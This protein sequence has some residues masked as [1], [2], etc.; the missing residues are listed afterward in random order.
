M[1]GGNFRVGAIQIAETAAFAQYGIPRQITVQR[2]TACPDQ[3]PAVA[4]A[5]LGFAADLDAGDTQMPK[6]QKKQRRLPL[7][8]AGG[9]EDG[10]DDGV[11]AD[12]VSVY[13][14]HAPCE[15]RID[16]HLPL[17]RIQMRKTGAGVR[18]A[19]PE[20]YLYPADS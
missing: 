20:L 5:G 2:R 1:V 14:N 17:E 19:P 12:V 4:A 13:I 8:D 6:A 16:A 10:R 18:D 15:P 9:G 7:A 11:V 3:R